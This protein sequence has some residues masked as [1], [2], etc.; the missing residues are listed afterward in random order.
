MKKLFLVSLALITMTATQAQLKVVPT[1]KKGLEKVYETKACMT[2]PGQSAINM[3]TDTKFSV[4]EATADG[5]VIDVVTTHFTSDAAANNIAAQILSA[6]QEMIKDVNI[7]VATDKNGKP[8]NIVNYNEVSK[9][10]DERSK[11]M[12]NKIYELIPEA[13]SMI[14]EDALKQQFIESLSEDALFKSMAGNNSPLLLF[15]KTIMT[16]AQE[17][18]VNEQ[19]LNMK[20]MYFVN[21]KDVTT[22]ATLNMSKEQV[23]KM[24]IAQVEKT[25]PAQADAIK[26]QID[27]LMESGMLKVD[28]KET[29]T[30]KLQDDFWP[31]S[32]TTEVSTE[33]AGQQMVTKTTTTLK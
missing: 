24:I 1:L 18:F 13:K 12:V 32:W 22:N 20:R 14:P 25:M 19:G 9:Q 4:S 27:Q 21:G 6:A 7:R 3:T 26:G 30:F 31:A 8:M 28:A 2:L 5:Y 29:T 16:G 33:T 15:G 23:K 10:L 17:E 11:Q